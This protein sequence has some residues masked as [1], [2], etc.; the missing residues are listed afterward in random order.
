MQLQHLASKIFAALIAVSSLTFVAKAS[1]QP[2][3]VG[4]SDWPAPIRPGLIRDVDEGESIEVEVWSVPASEFGS[5]VA[6]IPHPLSIGKVELEDGR[7]VSGFICESAAV[8]GAR[9]ITDQGAWR[10]FIASNIG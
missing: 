3:I 4:Y 5:F 10:K 2:L 9:E 6:H 8:K 1:A 7:W